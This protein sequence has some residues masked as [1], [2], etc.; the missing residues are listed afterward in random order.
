M[1]E[2]NA[3]GGKKRR[4]SGECANWHT[5]SFTQDFAPTRQAETDLP[6]R[7]Q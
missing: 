4:R 5:G 1:L 6:A 2:T 3:L 7:G